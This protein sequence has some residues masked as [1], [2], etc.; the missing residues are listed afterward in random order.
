M[1]ASEFAAAARSEKEVR[2]V[3]PGSVLGV[4]TPI[5]IVNVSG[6]AYVR[7]YKAARGRWYQSVLSA[8]RFVLEIAGSDVLVEAERVSEPGLIREVSDAYSKKYAG[9][10]ETPDMLTDAVAATTLRLGPA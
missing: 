3:V 6:D 9:E 2:V 5:W 10:P 4:R 7:S 1:D 8:G